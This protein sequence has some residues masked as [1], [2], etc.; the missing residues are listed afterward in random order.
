MSAFY[1]QTQQH[2]DTASQTA[3]LADALGREPASSY[4][5]SSF[6]FYAEPSRD[7]HKAG[8]V[9]AVHQSTSPLALTVSGCYEGYATIDGRR[10]VVWLAMSLAFL[11]GCRRVSQQE[12]RQI[13]PELFDQIDADARSDQSHDR[14]QDTRDFFDFDLAECFERSEPGQA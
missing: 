13:H 6:D 8:T 11:S 5:A 10:S 4:A 1:D 2:P 9:A 14:H 7:G 3:L 12:A